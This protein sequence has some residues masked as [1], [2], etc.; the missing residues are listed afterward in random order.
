MCGLGMREVVAPAV[1]WPAHLE[2]ERAD[3]AISTLGTTWK[4]AGSWP[5]FEAV[6]HDAVIGFARAARAAGARQ[7]VVMSSVG[8]AP[9]SRNRYLALKGRVEQALAEIGFERLD[10][11][12]PGLLRGERGTDRRF[13]ERLGIV[14]SPLANLLLRG[15]LD[16]FAAIDA[17]TVAVAIAALAGANERGTFVHRNRQIRALAAMQGDATGLTR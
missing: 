13:G 3:I 14:V 6:D 9:A 4:K 7:F 5:A 12:Q 2:R 8:A 17:S 10:I 16:R 1:E 11:I 15:R